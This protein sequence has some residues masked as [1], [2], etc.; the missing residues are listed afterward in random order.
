MKK[1]KFLNLLLIALLS[2]ALLLP[3]LGFSLQA[4][5]ESQAADA[6]EAPAEDTA[7]EEEKAEPAEAEPSD[8]EA[9]EDSTEEADDLL[10]PPE[11]TMVAKINGDT[12]ISLLEMNFQAGLLFQQLTQTPAFVPQASSIL[13]SP[14]PNGE[15]EDVPLRDMILDLLQEELSLKA[16]VVKKAQAEGVELGEDDLALVDKFFASFAQNAAQNGLSPDQ[17][18]EQFFGPGATAD[19]LRP[20]VEKDLLQSIY[21]EDLYNSYEISDEEIQAE[22]EANTANYDLVDFLLIQLDAEISEDDLAAVQKLLPELT[23]A[24]FAE[25]LAPY[26]G[27]DEKGQESLIA[28]SLQKGVAKQNMIPASADWLYDPARQAGDTTLVQGAKSQSALLFLSRYRD[29]T[30]NFDSRHILIKQ[31]GDTDLDYNVATA[32][33][34]ALVEGLKGNIDEDFF[35]ELAGKYSQD[36]G[37]NKNGGLYEDVAPGSFVKPYEDF[38]LNPATQVGQIGLVHVSQEEAGYAGYHIIYFKGLRD[39]NWYRAADSTLRAARQ[40]AMLDQL[41]AE[42]SF[43]YIN[44]GRE[45]IMPLATPVSGEEASAPEAM[46]TEEA[47]VPEAESSS[48]P[49]AEEPGTSEAEEVSEE[50]STETPSA[51]ENSEQETQK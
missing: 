49:E 22:Y 37:S 15:G 5:E 10:P 36:P 1:A 19:K 44:D 16:K 48:T 25:K 17:L 50:A 42:S 32:T 7:A 40:S 34:N 35:A 33:V 29:E 20:L 24:D 8:P 45:L 21:L 14:V 30:Q 23:E 47:S 13:N 3:N 2:L 9:A 27:K 4:E 43:E 51:E 38:C 46:A 6:T 31:A 18:L 41:K 26:S 11:K 12:S 39:A 28:N